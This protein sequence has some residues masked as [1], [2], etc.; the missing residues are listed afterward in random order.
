MLAKALKVI[1]LLIHA[2]FILNHALRACDST[3]LII[4]GI[5]VLIAVLGNV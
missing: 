5:Y 4:V 3:Y 1:N 2:A